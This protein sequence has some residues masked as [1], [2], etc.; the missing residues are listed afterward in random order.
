MKPELD[1]NLF[2]TTLPAVKASVVIELAKVFALILSTWFLFSSVT[3]YQNAKGNKEAVQSLLQDYEINSLA[4]RQERTRIGSSDPVKRD[5]LN[6]EIEHIN[7]VEACL[8][9]IDVTTYLMP[10]VRSCETQGV[11][12]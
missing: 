7:Q 1:I 6:R 5:R 3:S 10:Q 8:L 9:Q 12:S 4:A 11:Q 2:K